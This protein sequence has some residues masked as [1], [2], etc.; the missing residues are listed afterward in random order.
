[1]VIG[2]PA[3]EVQLLP[4]HNDR[5]KLRNVQT[6]AFLASLTIAAHSGSLSTHFVSSILSEMN[7]SERRVQRTH[8]SNL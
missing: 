3:N 2:F 6:S 4:S 1:D 7:F 5:V 8:L